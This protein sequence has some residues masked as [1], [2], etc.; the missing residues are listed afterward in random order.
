[1]SG[2]T[3]PGKWQPLRTEITEVG[4]HVWSN[5]SLQPIRTEITEVGVHGLSNYSWQP[6][7]QRLQKLWFMAGQTVPG[8]Q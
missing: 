2:K 4:V 3:V 7:E 1:M 6:I 5:C 8:N